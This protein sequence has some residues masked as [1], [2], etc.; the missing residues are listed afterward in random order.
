M[1]IDRSFI[2]QNR[3][4]T[5]RIRTLVARL[6][7]QELLKP[8]GKDWTVA[9]TLTHLAFWD[10]RM[11]HALEMTER[12]GK[13]FIPE[14]HLSVNDFSAPLW[15]AIPPRDAAMLAVEAAECVDLRLEALG[16][17]SKTSATTISTWSFG[18]TH[19]DEHLD[20]IDAALE[21]ELNTCR[22][23]FSPDKNC[24]DL[25]K[26]YE[27]PSPVNQTTFVPSGGNVKQDHPVQD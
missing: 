18:L 3:T 22:H 12:G 23:G 25:P 24:T 19:R 11:L 16:F 13:L 27:F 7:N 5:N 1:P 14:I 17:C 9:I 26:P 21:K 6:N 10:R 4:S 15:R 2:Q 8:V 20:E